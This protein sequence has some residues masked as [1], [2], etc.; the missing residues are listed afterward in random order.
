M[1]QT[2]VR[3]E[4]P[5][6][7]DMVAKRLRDAPVYVTPRTLRVADTAD[8]VDVLLFLDLRI[9]SVMEEGIGGEDVAKHPLELVVDG[10]R[11]VRSSAAH[12]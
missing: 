2:T 12:V 4:T 8:L 1:S 11:S 9:Y 5:G 3:C 10:R 6:Q 7:A